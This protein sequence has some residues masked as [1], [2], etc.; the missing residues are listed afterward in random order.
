MRFKVKIVCGNENDK[1][2][3]WILKRFFDKKIGY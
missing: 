3:G 2:V 1:M